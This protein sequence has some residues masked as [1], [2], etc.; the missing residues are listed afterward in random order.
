[1]IFFCVFLIA[2]ISSL[3]ETEVPSIF[4]G[5]PLLPWWKESFVP[6]LLPLSDSTLFFFSFFCD[7]AGESEAASAE[8]AFCSI[9]PPRAPLS[10]FYFLR[11][12]SGGVRS[13]IGLFL[14]ASVRSSLAFLWSSVLLGKLEVASAERA[15]CPFFSIFIPFRCN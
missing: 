10:S 4:S 13:S 8:E 14:T 15:F 2:L 1:M 12:L 5:L 9:S 7:L 6:I 11:F 3:E